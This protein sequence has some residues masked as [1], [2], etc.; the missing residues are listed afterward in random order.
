[1]SSAAA[2][3]PFHRPTTVAGE[4][5]E[6]AAAIEGG[7]LSGDGAIGQ[8]V[9][10]LLAEHVQVP[11]VLLTPSGTAALELAALALDL[12]PGDEV[13]VPSF[14]FPSTANA[15]V[16]RGATVVFAEVEEATLNLDV[17]HA[18]SLVTER[19]RAVLPIHYGGVASQVDELDGLAER[20]GLDVV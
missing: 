5:R 19:T 11:R 9:E 3:V 1:M 12:G 6:V 16:L 10:R 2:R 18:A 13:I 7:A 14:A 8:E 17:S 15:V 4:A 20:H